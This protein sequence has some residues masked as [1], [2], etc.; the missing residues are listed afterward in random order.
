[1]LGGVQRLDPHVAQPDLVAVAEQPVLEAL[2]PAVLPAL[3]A[4]VGEAEGGPGGLGELAGAGEVVGVDVGLGDGHDA[5]L[6]ALGIGQVDAD[7]APVVGQP[8]RW[9][10]WASPS[11]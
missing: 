10:A 9:L 5:W 11:S 6:V 3:A 4:L 7:V 8:T 2:Q 1:V